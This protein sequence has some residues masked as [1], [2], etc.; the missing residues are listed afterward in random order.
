V[1]YATLDTCRGKAKVSLGV[2]WFIYIFERDREREKEKERK[3]IDETYT[4]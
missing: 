3:K 4:Q 1:D 2:V